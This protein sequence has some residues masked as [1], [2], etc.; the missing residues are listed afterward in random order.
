MRQSGDGN[1]WRLGSVEGET[2]RLKFCFG[3]GGFELTVESHLGEGERAKV[4]W[5]GWDGLDWVEG[6]R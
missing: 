5:V 4:G 3:S 1:E 2:F 6:R